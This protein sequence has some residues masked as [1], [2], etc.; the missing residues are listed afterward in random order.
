MHDIICK[1]RGTYGTHSFV[2][3][4]AQSHF[5]DWYAPEW[6]SAHSTGI[7]ASPTTGHSITKRLRPGL[8]NRKHPS[9]SRAPMKV[10]DE[11]MQDYPSR[12]LRTQTNST[13]NREAQFTSTGKRSGREPLRGNVLS[14]N[15]KYTRLPLVS[16][17]REGSALRVVR[18]HFALC[19][20]GDIH[21]FGKYRSLDGVRDQKEVRPF[22]ATRS[23]SRSWLM[24]TSRT[25]TVLSSNSD[26]RTSNLQ[27]RLR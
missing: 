20:S 7:K 5:R 18:P 27:P 19:T 25:G 9:P 14:S 12:C 3:V 16:T 23:S 26:S 13:T 15:E 6:L 22:A 4:S 11:G 1:Q 2:V 17:R 8:M 21:T 24:G 10:P